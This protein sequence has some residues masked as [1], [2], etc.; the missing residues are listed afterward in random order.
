MAG[1]V[2][3]LDYDMYDVAIHV[4]NPEKVPNIENLDFK[5]AYI[6]KEYTM[7]QIGARLFYSGISAI[8]FMAYATKI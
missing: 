3:R 7:I 8:V 2:S 1:F 5:I 6:N 4:K